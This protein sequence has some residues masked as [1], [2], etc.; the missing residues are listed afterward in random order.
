VLQIERSANHGQ[1][2]RAIGDRS[3]GEVIEDLGK[4]CRERARSIAGLL[5]L[6]DS[7]IVDEQ[8]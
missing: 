2:Q 1:P 5:Q 6:S 4:G 3:L 7:E 8:L